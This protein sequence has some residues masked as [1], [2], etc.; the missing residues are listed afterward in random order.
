MTTLNLPGAPAASAHRTRARV[1][2]VFGTRPEAIKLAP[3]IRSLQAAG[4]LA[5]VICSTGQHREML[6]QM[7]GALCLIPQYELGLMRERQ[8]LAS[9]T[10]LAV[11]ALGKVIQ[12]EQPAAVVVQGD[13]TTCLCGALAAFYEHV[14]VA[15]VEAGLR[16]G[17]P[18]NP[19]PEEVNRRLVAQMARWHFAPT[20]AAAANL[21]REGIAGASIS[22]TGNTGIDTLH[23]VLERRLGRSRFRTSLRR[24]LVTVHRRENQG[25]PMRSLA[26]AIGRLA[27][28][29]DTEVLLPMHKSPAVRD[30]IAPALADVPNVTLTEPLGYFDFIASLADCDLVLTDSG[31]V[32]EEAPSLGKPVLVLRQ[33][34]ERPEAIQAGVARL[35][36]TNP[37]IVYQ[38]AAQLLDDPDEYAA[39]AHAVSPFGDGHAAGRVVSQLAADLAT[40]PGR[41]G[42]NPAAA[43]SVAGG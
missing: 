36:G 22:V 27:A 42:V 19:F 25:A 5:V 8:T 41:A 18:R 32:Q 29:G 28:R 15:H 40:A 17:D 38:E 16:S 30:D 7:I 23:W 43:T 37:A 4:E 39:M 31:G 9:L 6:G 3:V 26:V 12:R 33:T 1:L 21:H 10:G 20:Q 34:T 11:D 35:V 13:T 2:V 24:V 14:P